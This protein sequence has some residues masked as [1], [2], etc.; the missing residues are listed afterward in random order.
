MGFLLGRHDVASCHDGK[1]GGGPAMTTERDTFTDE[2]VF[3]VGQ[4]F[5]V[6]IVTIG[7]SV[8]SG[9]IGTT[10]YLVGGQPYEGLNRISV[11]DPDVSDHEFTEALTF[12]ESFD[13]PF[14]VDMPAAAA[15]RFTSVM[16]ARGFEVAHESPVLL[17]DNPELLAKYRDPPGVSCELVTA[18][19]YGAF[20]AIMGEVFEFPQYI[21]DHG[22][23]D[24]FPLKTGRMPIRLAYVDGE[25]AGVAQARVNGDAIGVFNI[26]VVERFR[27][28][29]LG[30]ALTH[31]SIADGIALGGTFALLGATEMGYPLYKSMGFRDAGNRTAF[32]AKSNEVQ[33]PPTT[34]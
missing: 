16:A 28:R 20:E 11:A 5:V 27:G 8:A 21:F 33:S 9:Y 23:P 3:T 2:D 25:L 14:G 6:D 17:L 26:G 32:A 30:R 15:R 34:D 4:A 18:A 12:V 24:M 22:W 1:F 19:N 10:G 29:G 7:P 31:A 13:V